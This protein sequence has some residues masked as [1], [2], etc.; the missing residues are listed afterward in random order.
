MMLVISVTWMD[1]RQENYP[2]S[3]HFVKDGELVVYEEYGI[4]GG[5]KDEWHFP[6]VNIRVWKPER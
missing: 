2:A 4:T 5:V 1:G 3:Y 6:L